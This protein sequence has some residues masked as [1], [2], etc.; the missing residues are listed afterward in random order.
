MSREFPWAPGSAT[1]IGSLPGTDVVEAVKAVFG[2]LPD[3]P[4]LPELPAR[5]PGADM[6]GRAAGL[7]VDMPVELYAGAWRMAS[8]SGRDAQ[9]TADLWE[10]DLDAL[11]DYTSEYTGLVK[12]Q[13][14]GVWTLAA[15]LDLPIGGRMLRDAGA[16][17]DLAASLAEGVAGHV[18][19]IAA[20]LPGA[21]VLLQLDE[22]ALPAVLAGRIPTES[23][24]SVL[25]PVEAAVAT[26]AVAR[27]VAAAGV[28]VVLHCCA[29]DAPVE[30]ARE[31]GAVA[32][33]IDLDLVTDLDALGEALDAGLGLFAGA[34]PTGGSTAAGDAGTAPGASG[35][36]AGGGGSAAG[37]RSTGGGSAGGRR[38][39][40]A[41][42]G[43]PTS[44]GRSAAS[45]DRSWADDA[46]GVDG[47][48][49]GS[50]GAADDVPVTRMSAAAATRVRDLWR[51]IGF[52]INDLPAQVVVTPACGLARMPPA[53]ARTITSACRQA[54][55]RLA[56]D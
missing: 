46:P 29:P 51:T 36:V 3:L 55:R 38:S 53:A 39:A 22:P 12:V 17:R 56:D 15:A 5:G 34:V 33:A 14:A 13:V 28:P 40:M 18:R 16:V 45:G 52:S 23:G 42:G 47:A 37:R 31:A 6:I 2:E 27:V 43:G 4:Y 11:T 1:G 50:A 7:L 19:E 48:V 30:L 44:G 9:R 8:H 54:A 35:T 32:I 10:R 20:R 25:P 49:D 41:L 24:F 26:E 21:R